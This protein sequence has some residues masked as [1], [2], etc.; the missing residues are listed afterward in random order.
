M[1]E[2]KKGEKYMTVYV[3][4]DKPLCSILNR[5][6]IHKHMFDQML[7]QN[8]GT[9]DM[10]PMKFSNQKVMEITNITLLYCIVCRCNFCIIIHKVDLSH[11]RLQFNCCK[12]HQKMFLTLVCRCRKK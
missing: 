8:L 6:R 7:V 10:V 3:T 5:H 4:Y 12:N 2:E 11:H 1:E 9:T